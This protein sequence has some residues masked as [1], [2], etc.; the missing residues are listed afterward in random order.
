VP[1]PP[2]R[3]AV[4]LGASNVTNSLRHIVSILG[5]QAGGP[6]EILA[7]CGHGRSYGGWSSFLGLR[8]LPGI[9][10]SGLWRALAARRLRQPL[11]TVALLTDIGNDL[12]YGE[13][14][15]RIVSWVERCLHELAD[16]P[17]AT[18]LTLLPIARL[19]RLTPWQFRL[20]SAVLF[21]TRTLVH[22]PL[23]SQAH[24][25]DA[26]LRRLGRE[27]GAAVVEP[28]PAWF[29]LD[30]V[31]LRR[32]LARQAWDSILGSWPEEQQGETARGVGRLPWPL[33]AEEARLLRWT[34]LTPQPCA[35]LADGT[36]LSLY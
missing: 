23:L 27:A 24:A 3:R 30:P 1:P 28:D 26:E 34:V 16:C 33:R 11:P 10:G 15:E 13:P 12:A 4:L 6:V 36:S 22:A 17:A 2:V 29:G 19:E 20:A 8:H 21:P 14:V 32:G 31:H 5:R 7:A 18:L 35:R 9:V 25:L